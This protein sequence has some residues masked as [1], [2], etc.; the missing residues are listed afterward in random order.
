M[1][2]LFKQKMSSLNLILKNI[3]LSLKENYLGD[4]SNLI[5]EKYRSN[6]VCFGEASEVTYI[7][8]KMIPKEFKKILVVG[9]FGGRDYFYFKVN[10]FETYGLDLDIIPEIDNLTIA[11]IEKELP[12]EDRFFDVI[13]LS[14]VLEHLIKDYDAIQNL[15]RVLRDDGLIIFSIPFLHDMEETHVRLYT[16]K[17]IERF[18]KVCGLEILEFIERPTFGFYISLINFTNHF[19]SIITYTFLKQTI[20]KISLPILWKLSYILGKKRF[21]LRRFSKRWGGYYSCKKSESTLN[22]LAFNKE[23]FCKKSS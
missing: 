14:E 6:F 16:P 15:K 5:P 22:Y 11:N 20:Y 13:I 10:G 1:L 7:F 23:I 19:F 9:I 17:I 21:F 12:F 8:S 18:F 3:Y 4:K 2:V